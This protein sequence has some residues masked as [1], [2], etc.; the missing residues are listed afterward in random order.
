VFTLLQPGGVA[1][2]RR[3]VAG[4]NRSARLA[5][6]DGGASTDDDQGQHDLI[7]PDDADA[8]WWQQTHTV[9]CGGSL[10]RERAAGW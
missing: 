1:D 6:P 5:R 2:D 4:D 7:Q 8:A 9:S 10:W 3:E